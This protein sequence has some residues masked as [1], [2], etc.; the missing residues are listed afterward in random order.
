MFSKIQLSCLS[1]CFCISHLLHE[2]IISHLNQKNTLSSICVHP[3]RMTMRWRGMEM[4]RMSMF[5]STD[6]AHL[7][8]AEDAI[9]SEM[10]NG[11]SL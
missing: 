4:R 5:P 6:P 11:K 2:F 7:A 1:P 9:R 3:G 8:L 10:E